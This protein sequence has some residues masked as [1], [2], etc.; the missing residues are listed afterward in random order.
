MPMPRSLPGMESVDAKMVRAH[1]N[2]EA[3]GREIN[4]WFSTIKINM[5][6]TTALDEAWPWL[7][8]VATDYIPPIRLSVLVAECVHNMRSAVDN[9]IRALTRTT[10][11]SSKCHGL[12]FPL[13]KG[14]NEWNEKSDKSLKGIP[15]AAKDIIQQ[16]QPW[17]D[18]SAPKPLV[19]PNKLSYVDKHRAIQQECG[20]PDPLPQ[21]RNT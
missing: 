5:Y 7:V 17:S 20:F 8:V 6:L 16:L 14:L 10:N 15:Q 21:R 19:I 9:L 4:D 2:I 13:L 3:L 18:M 11:P 1:E 12:A